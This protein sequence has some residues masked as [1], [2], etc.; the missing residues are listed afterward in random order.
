MNPTLALCQEPTLD[1]YLP[2]RVRVGVMALDDRQR[3]AAFV[4]YYGLLYAQNSP[5][6]AHDLVEFMTDLPVRKLSPTNSETLEADISVDELGA[7]VFKIQSGKAPAPNWY[8]IEFFKANWLLL[9]LPPSW[10][11]FKRWTL[12]GYCLVT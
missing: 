3:A 2:Y 8:A 7:A 4:Q 11:S 6:N 10:L 12:G 1:A 9:E 5:P